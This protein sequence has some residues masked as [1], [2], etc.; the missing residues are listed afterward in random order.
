VVVPLTTNTGAGYST[1]SYSEPYA[2]ANSSPFLPDKF[3]DH[4][5]VDEDYGNPYWHPSSVEDE[6]RMQL[7]RLKVQ[8]ISREDVQ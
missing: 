5:E 6:L 4:Y 8:E 7:L 1:P 3:S 2:Y